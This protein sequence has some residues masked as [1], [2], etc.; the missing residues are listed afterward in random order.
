MPSYLHSFEKLR[1]VME[2]LQDPCEYTGCGVLRGEEYT[3]Y[4]V[5]DLIITQVLR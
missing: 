4:V 1:V 5:G 2:V 3:D